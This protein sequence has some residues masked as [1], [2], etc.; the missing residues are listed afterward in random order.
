MYN[1]VHVCHSDF[2]TFAGIGKICPVN[3]ST[4]QLGSCS[5][6]KR[7]TLFGPQSLCNRTFWW[8]SCFVA[9]LLKKFLLVFGCF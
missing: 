5:L 6:F 4:I 3:R 2:T 1:I 9:L 8:C 7:P